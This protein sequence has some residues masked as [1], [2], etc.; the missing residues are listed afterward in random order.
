[1]PAVSKD[2]GPGGAARA[3]MVRDA[4]ASPPIL[5]MRGERIKISAGATG[6]RVQ[7]PKSSLR[8]RAVV[9]IDWVLARS[10]AGPFGV[11][12]PWPVPL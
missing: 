6:R 2:A 9:A 12:K 3:A 4:R 10:S 5:T 7:M 1:L 8:V 11:E